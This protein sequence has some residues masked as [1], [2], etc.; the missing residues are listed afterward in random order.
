MLQELWAGEAVLCVATVCVVVEKSEK[1]WVQLKKPSKD[2]N[3]TL[4]E[5][6]HC[7]WVAIFQLFSGNN[8]HF[9]LPYSSGHL[10]A[11]QKCSVLRFMLTTL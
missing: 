3:R 1:S 9:D 5:R 8:F 2:T 7:T 4:F 11:A 6:W 10:R